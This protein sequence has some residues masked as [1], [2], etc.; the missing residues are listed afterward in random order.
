MTFVDEALD[1]ETIAYQVGRGERPLTVVDSNLLASI[2]TYNPDLE[3][4]FVLA[5]G[6]ELAWVVRSEARELA[7]ALDAF[8]IERQLTD[9]RADDRTTGDLDSVRARG[10]LRVITLNN[11]GALLPL[12]RPA[13]GLRLRDREPAARKLGVVSSLVPRPAISPSNGFEGRGLHR[14]DADGHS[15][16]PRASRFQPTVPLR[17]RGRGPKSANGRQ[18]VERYEP[19]GRT[20]H[21]WKSSSHYQTLPEMG[22]HGWARST[23]SRS[24]DMEYEEISIESRAA[25]IGSRSWDSLVLEAELHIATTWRRL[26]L[27]PDNR[28]RSP[29]P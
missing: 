22:F 18:S 12:P 8:I 16:T 9:H 23:S 19:A 14:R 7:A 25:S 5:R 15:R 20:V 28:S 13:D 26:S 27:R 1:T 24:Q 11:P 6:R 29:S 4:L 17:R 3:P 21:A 2:E 10:S